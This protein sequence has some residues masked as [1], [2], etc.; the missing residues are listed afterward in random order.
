MRYLLA[1]ALIF[2]FMTASLDAHC[3]GCNSD[4]HDK[5][6][7]SASVEKKTYSIIETAKKAE[8]F[9]TLLTAI[10]T[11]GL[12]KALA[13]EGPFTVFAPTDEAFA[14]LPEGTVEALLK[15]KKKLASILTYHVLEG[16]VKS[17]DVVKID[18]AQT[19]NGQSVSI[20]VSDGE[21]NIDNAKVV[22][23][24]IMCDNGIIHV[25]DKVI[26]PRMETSEK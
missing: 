14:A 7:T 18:K 25:I 19:L 20:K 24:D 5:T 16:A 12:D 3:G 4:K 26:L 22:M 2:G 21:V 10:E 15:D 23:V 9:K 17:A 6:A 11:A 13:G 1:F 8:S